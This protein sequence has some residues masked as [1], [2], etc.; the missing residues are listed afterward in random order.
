MKFV[1]EK[2]IKGACY[3]L[4]ENESEH[5]YI[6]SSAF[7]VENKQGKVKKYPIPNPSHFCFC[8]DGS[9]IALLDTSGQLFIV[10]T[11]SDAVTKISA[12]N[13]GEGCAP[14]FLQNNI[15][16]ANWGGKIFKYNL[17]DKKTEVIADFSDQEIM[18]V[19][20]DVNKYKNE[21]IATSYSRKNSCYCLMCKHIDEEEFRFFNLPI[22]NKG[23]FQG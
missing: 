11:Q 22:K 13:S 15:Y 18:I 2:A 6:N 7:M 20:L 23:L 1:K 4:K 9:V 3:T 10:N 19:S 12:D 17:S 8:D 14:M 21:I 16:W 5:F